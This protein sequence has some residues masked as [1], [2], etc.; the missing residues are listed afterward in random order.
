MPFGDPGEGAPFESPIED[1]T[2][3][4]WLIDVKDDENRGFGPTL[5]WDMYVYDRAAQN[6]VRLDNGDP[7]VLSLLSS[8]K[9]TKS[10]KGNSK[11]YDWASAFAAQ[12]IDEVATTGAE[13]LS[14]IREK[15][16]L[17]T[18]VHNAKGWPQV[19][20]EGMR[21]WAEPRQRAS[22]AAPAAAPADAPA[23]APTA[24]APAAPPQPARPAAAA[25]VAADDEPFD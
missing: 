7:F 18:I 2:Y 22:A 24:A 19:P 13:V 25:A 6:Q 10:E 3:S 15:W 8:D 16:A 14:A 11:A 12:P 23:P 1:G 20:Q 21:P 4:V 5:R 17:A 9:V